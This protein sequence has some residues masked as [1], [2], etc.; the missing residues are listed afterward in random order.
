[1]IQAVDYSKY[2]GSEVFVIQYSVSYTRYTLLMLR[3]LNQIYTFVNFRLGFSQPSP[4]ASNCIRTK[5]SRHI[6]VKPGH[7][8]PARFWLLL[9]SHYPGYLM[10]KLTSYHKRGKLIA[11]NR[12][13]NLTTNRDAQRW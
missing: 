1:M 9:S 11:S 6:S 12:L 8:R 2:F 10:K 13:L 5:P 4:H 3:I 7:H